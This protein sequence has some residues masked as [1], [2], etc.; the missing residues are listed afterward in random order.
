MD[1]REK[2]LQSWV[3]SFPYDRYRNYPGFP[4]EQAQRVHMDGLLEEGPHIRKIWLGDDPSPR[5]LL[6]VVDLKWDESIYKVRM[7]HL[8]HTLGPISTSSIRDALADAGYCHVVTRVDASDFTLQRRLLEEGFF[9]ADT[10]LT[11]ITLPLSDWPADRKCPTLDPPFVIRD[12]EPRDRRGVLEVTQRMYSRYPSRYYLD[13]FLREHSAERYTLWMEKCLDGEADKTLVA[14]SD[15]NVTAFL[16]FKYDRRLYQRTQ[17]RCYG[18]GIGASSA[19]GRGAYSRILYDAIQ[20]AA[21]MGA[22]YGEF[23]TQIDNYGVLSIYHQLGLRY[24]RAQHT[25]HLHL[26]PLSL[27]E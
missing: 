14:E 5:G 18:A 16:S 3:Q 19:Q 10:L 25:F 2:A 17:I 12:Y 8:T 11:Y 9:L 1:S 21:E 20:Y 26:P 22:K 13:P 15:G 6:R 24:V 7:G 23:D 4:P 27:Q